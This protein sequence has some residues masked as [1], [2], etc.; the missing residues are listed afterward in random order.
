MKLLPAVS[1]VLVFLTLVPAPF[2]GYK[3][4]PWA[5]RAP[6]TYPARLT[7]EK[8]TIAVEPLYRDALAASVFDTKTMVTAGIMPL[9][10]VVFNDNDFPVSLQ[11]ASIEL[12][13]RE[14]RIRTL[15]TVEVLRK[16]FPKAANA[17]IGPRGASGKSLNRGDNPAL[18]DLDNKFLDDRTIPAHGKSGGFLFFLVPQRPDITGYLSGS[19][20]YIPEVVR[21]DTGAN[22]IFFEIELQ[23]ALQPAAK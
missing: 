4:R 21:T 9:A 16:V 12:L 13:T 14:D 20:V 17:I 15:E 2:A 11:A 5:P 10:V 7:S 3:A 19:T 23:P 22:L 1:T 6:E 18:D 8:V